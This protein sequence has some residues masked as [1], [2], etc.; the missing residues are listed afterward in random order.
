MCQ[1]ARKIPRQK[2]QNFSREGAQPP[3]QTLPHWGGGPPPQTPPPARDAIKACNFSFHPYSQFSIG[4]CLTKASFSCTE[5]SLYYTTLSVLADFCSALRSCPSSLVVSC[6]HRSTI[7][8]FFAKTNNR[9]FWQYHLVIGINVLTHFV[10]LMLISLLHMRL[11]CATSTF[12]LSSL[13]PSITRSFFHIRL[14]I[15]LLYKF[16]PHGLFNVHT[17]SIGLPVL[18]CRTVFGFRILVFCFIF[19][20]R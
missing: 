5:S 7:F 2:I 18:N 19:V 10:G 11:I 3:P 14:K 15:H 13:S 1:N 16:F 9:S 8:I 4:Y 6:H 17:L 12:S 20:S